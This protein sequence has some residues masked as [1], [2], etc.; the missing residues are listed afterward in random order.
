[1]FYINPADER[2]G[3]ERSDTK[4]LYALTA[5]KK[6]YKSFKETRNM[7]LFVTKEV[8]MDQGEF[9][10]FANDHRECVLEWCKLR[11]KKDDPYPKSMNESFGNCIEE[12]KF[13]VTYLEKQA[14]KEEQDRLFEHA[15]LELPNPLFFHK[16]LKSVFK[17]FGLDHIFKLTRFPYIGDD[18]MYC[19]DEELAIRSTNSKMKYSDAAF[20]REEMDFSQPDIWVDE[21]EVFLEMYGHLMNI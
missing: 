2:P 17:R 7:K 12:Y 8:S 11:S 3:S 16:S 1:M 14:V 20:L 15:D 21:V 5:K 19:T 18:A 10:C 13:A 9:S 4:I 6:L